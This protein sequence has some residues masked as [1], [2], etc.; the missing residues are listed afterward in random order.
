MNI[1]F[2][3]LFFGPL[4]TAADSP[5]PNDCFQWLKLTG[6]DVQISHL[7][8]RGLPVEGLLQE[9]HQL[10]SLLDP[11]T[12]ETE[13][14]TPT[15]EDFVPLY[16][17]LEDLEEYLWNHGA[18]PSSED[19]TEE[20]FRKIMA[21]RLLQSPR[22]RPPVTLQTLDPS[23]QSL[24]MELW[25]QNASRHGIGELD[26]KLLADIVAVLQA[27]ST[28]VLPK[29][30]QTKTQS[31][32]SDE[33]ARVLVAYIAK[34]RLLKAYPSVVT[35]LSNLFLEEK[36]YPVRRFGKLL[37][38]LLGT[39][40]TLYHVRDSESLNRFLQSEDRS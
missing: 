8:Q 17:Q 36:Q 38:R 16:L 9:R 28:E 18:G 29:L 7:R 33:N 10:M 14:K 40:D 5:D 24:A 11:V 35:D 1:L 13:A 32:P 21:H 20:V 30:V 19:V 25:L 6:L 3:L 27:D 12:D 31:T 22:Y 2:L 26:P 23:L 4:A 15:E 39:S 37:D 34:N